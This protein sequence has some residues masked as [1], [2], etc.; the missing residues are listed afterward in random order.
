MRNRKHDLAEKRTTHLP[1]ALPEQV[2]EA[3]AEVGAIPVVVVLYLS[4]V[5]S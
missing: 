1:A 5:Q 2:D 3:A 4:D